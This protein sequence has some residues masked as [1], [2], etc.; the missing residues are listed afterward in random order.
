MLRRF[1]H[2]AVR[3]L[4]ELV[5]GVFV[6]ASFAALFA[7]VR[8]LLGWLTGRAGQQ[9]LLA[10]RATALDWLPN[11]VRSWFEAALT[12]AP[13]LSLPPRCCRCCG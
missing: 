7:V 11:A 10:A 9:W 2:P 8:L 6:F 5:D 4:Q 12:L 13:A 1:G 3:L